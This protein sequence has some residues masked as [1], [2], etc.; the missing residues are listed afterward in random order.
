MPFIWDCVLWGYGMEQKE[1]LRGDSSWIA[2]ALLSRLFGFPISEYF[3]E[4]TDQSFLYQHLCISDKMHW[5]KSMSAHAL[6]PSKLLSLSPT[7]EAFP[8]NIKIWIVPIAKIMGHLLV[9]ISPLELDQNWVAGLGN[10]VENII[11]DSLT[12]RYRTCMWVCQA[13]YNLL[14]GSKN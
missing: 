4:C 12:L 1:F 6:S 10:Q 3:I 8:E 9:E 11:T 5:F 13:L 14:T 7:K 2:L